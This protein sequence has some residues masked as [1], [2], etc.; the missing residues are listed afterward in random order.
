MGWESTL[1]CKQSAFQ[2]FDKSKN[3]NLLGTVQEHALDMVARGQVHGPQWYKDLQQ[4]PRLF[5]ESHNGK[6][7]RTSTVSPI[8]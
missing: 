1:R 6:F 4:R 8:A 5:L 2:M 7:T 3:S